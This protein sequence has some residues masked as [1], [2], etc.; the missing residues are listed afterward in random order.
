MATMQSTK[1]AST[2]F[3]R[4]SP[5]PPVLVDERAVGHDEARDAA[6]TAVGRRPGGG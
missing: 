2:I 3:R 4:I 1:S 5:S 6:A